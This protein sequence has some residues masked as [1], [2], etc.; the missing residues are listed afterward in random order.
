MD[1]LKI[2]DTLKTLILDGYRKA[3]ISESKITEITNK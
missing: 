2:T 3:G 1:T